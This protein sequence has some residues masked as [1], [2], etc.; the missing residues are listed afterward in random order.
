MRTDSW[1]AYI[2]SSC[3]AWRLHYKDIPFD[4]LPIVYDGFL[5]LRLRMPISATCYRSTLL[6]SKSLP[7]NSDLYRAGPKY[8]S[9]RHTR[10]GSIK[11]GAGSV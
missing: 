2:D 9:R 1:N 5:S 11:S 8:W 6:D 7:G 10:V 4:A 3:D